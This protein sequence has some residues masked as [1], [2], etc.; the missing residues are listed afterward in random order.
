[1]AS[2]FNPFAG[3]GRI[4][5]YIRWNRFRGKSYAQINALLNKKYGSRFLSARQSAIAEEKQTEGTAT[6][7][8]RSGPNR[9]LASLTL[10]GGK[11]KSGTLRVVGRVTNSK[12][13]GFGGKLSNER[14]FVFDVP[15]MGTKRQLR[16][17]LRERILDAFFSHYDISNKYR[18]DFRK[19]F[20][21]VD[22]LDIEGV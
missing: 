20:G 11:N 21:N 2:S 16:T 18:N 4:G 7:L 13:R 9:E 17:T 3:L 12:F 22:I 8:N 10:P 15:R 5:S 6:A 1:M 14:A 19:R